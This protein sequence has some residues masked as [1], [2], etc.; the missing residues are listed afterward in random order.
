MAETLAEACAAH[1]LY[2]SVLASVRQLRTT[3]IE[4]GSTTAR[5]TCNFVSIVIF[6]PF[7]CWTIQFPLVYTQDSAL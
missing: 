2:C 7:S 5:R 1:K 6:L 4:R 3:M